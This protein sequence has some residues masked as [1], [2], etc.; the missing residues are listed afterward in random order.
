MCI[1]E[2]DLEDFKTEFK[3]LLHRYELELIK[4]EVFSLDEY[5]KIDFK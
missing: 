3:E 5:I 2:G 1:M 4:C